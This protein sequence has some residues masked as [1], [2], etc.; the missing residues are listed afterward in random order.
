MRHGLS[1]PLPLARFRVLTLTGGAFV[2]SYTTLS[3]WALPIWKALE[4]AGH[5]PRTVFVHAGLDPGLIDKPG[6]RYPQQ[7]LQACWRRA[8]EVTGDDGFGLT[9]AAHWHPTT[10]HA[11]G[12]AWLASRSLQ[13]GFQRLQRHAAMVATGTGAIT[14]RRTGERYRFVIPTRPSLRTTLVPASVDAVASV[15]VRMC[16]LSLGESFAPLAVRLPHPETPCR[17]RLEQH[18]ACPIHFDAE[19][20]SLELAAADIERELPTGN[21]ELLASSERIIADYLAHLVR[22]DAVA[23]A[24]AEIMRQLPGGR[25]SEES[26]AAALHLSLRTFQRRLRVAGTAYRDLLDG[27]RRELAENYLAN[28]RLSVTE[29]SYLLGFSEPSSFARSYRRWSG[30]APSEARQP[31]N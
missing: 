22:D 17:S 5:E 11:I 20:L 6:A 30:H 1:G 9:A 31:A 13:E 23:G 27:V 10:W 25:I 29:I 24:R 18:F 2:L 26:V 21:A 16:R 28:P 12:I 3:S 8:V 4:Q 7:G 15:L 14:F 19:A